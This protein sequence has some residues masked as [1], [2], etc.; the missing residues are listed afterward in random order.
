MKLA[1]TTVYDSIIL[2]DC[3]K[4]DS[5]A[6]ERLR[7]NARRAI[8]VVTRTEVLAGT[9]TDHEHITATALI[10][11]CENILVSEDIAD[12]AADLRKQY[13]LKTADAIIY[14]TARVLGVSLVTRDKAFPKEADVVRV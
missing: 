4:N 9:R 11:S 7:A 1:P 5:A 2:I 8:S 6:V 10:E 3:L 14:A 12:L 13:R